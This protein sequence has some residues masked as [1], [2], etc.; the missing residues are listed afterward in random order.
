MINNHDIPELDA[1]GLRQFALVTAGLFAV[2]FGL[3]FPWLLELDLPKWPFII[4]GVLVVWGLAAPASLR[5]VYHGWMRFALLLN[6]I[7]TPIVMSLIFFVLFVPTA[8][9]MRIIGRDT[10]MRKIDPSIETYRKPS[11]ESSPTKMERPF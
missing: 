7:V 3:F 5:P 4:A 1:K 9:Y 8:M 2:I 6:W 11:K 10:M